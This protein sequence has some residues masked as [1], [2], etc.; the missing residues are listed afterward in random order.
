M[1]VSN[2]AFELADRRA[3]EERAKDPEGKFLSECTGWNTY[4]KT[5]TANGVEGDP[6]VAALKDRFSK[7]CP[8]KP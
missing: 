6:Q 1:S 7:A 3:E 5:V 8:G 4:M 2:R